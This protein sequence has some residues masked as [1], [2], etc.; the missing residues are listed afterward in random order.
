MQSFGNSKQT[1][2]K[3]NTHTHTLKSVISNTFLVPIPS[4]PFNFQA[5]K[6]VYMGNSNGLTGS[7]SSCVYQEREQKPEIPKEKQRSMLADSQ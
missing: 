4:P 6:A 1:N 5:D 7:R 3:Q 2:N